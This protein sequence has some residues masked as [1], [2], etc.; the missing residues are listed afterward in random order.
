MK[1]IIVNQKPESPA[2][3]NTAYLVMNNDGTHKRYVSDNNGVVSENMDLNVIGGKSI[4]VTKV[5]NNVKVEYTGNAVLLV[6]ENF[7]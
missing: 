2:I 4:K 5:E 7:D 1:E 6:G 3:P